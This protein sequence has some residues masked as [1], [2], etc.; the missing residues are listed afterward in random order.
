MLAFCGTD[1]SPN[2][3]DLPSEDLGLDP[4]AS[5]KRTVTE[6]EQIA[7]VGTAPEEERSDTSSGELQEQR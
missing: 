4:V 7:Q 2:G 5:D 6:G 3:L 1:E